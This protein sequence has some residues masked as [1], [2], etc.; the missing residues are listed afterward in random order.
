MVCTL[1]ARAK[2]EKQQNTSKVENESN[3]HVVVFAG[4]IHLE[5]STK[6]LK[7]LRLFPVQ[8]GYYKIVYIT[9]IYCK[10]VI[11]KLIGTIMKTFIWF[12]PTN[13]NCSVSR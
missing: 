10:V 6:T 3:L 7:L 13:L 2:R 9:I 11:I 1:N 4:V 12:S 5:S 8:V